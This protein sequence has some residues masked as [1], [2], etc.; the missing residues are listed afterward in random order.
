MLKAEDFL[1]N[2]LSDMASLK[3]ISEIAEG[4]DPKRISDI[5][6]KVDE[7]KSKTVYMAQKRRDM[8]D[9]LRRM[10]D[11]EFVKFEEGPQGLKEVKLNRT[12]AQEIDKARDQFGFNDKASAMNDRV[13]TDALIRRYKQELSPQEKSLFDM[14]YIGTYSKGDRKALETLQKLEDSVGLKQPEMQGAFEQLKRNAVNT[15]LIREGVNSKEIS[16]TNLKKFFTNYEQLIKKSRVKLTEPQKEQL[17]REAEG[18]E[19]ITT[20]KDAEGNDIRNEFIDANLI[21]AKSKKYLDEVKPFTGLFEGKVKDPEMRRLYDSLTEHLE[22]YHNLDVIN[23]NGFFRGIFKKNINEA[24]KVDLQQLDRIFADMRDGTWW[25]NTMDYMT[26][27][28][29]N[30][31]IKKAYY[32]MFPKAIDRD[33][34]RNPAMMEWVDDVGPYKDKLGNTFENA[35]TVRPTSVIGTIQELAH[36]TQELSMQKYEDESSLWRDELR[37]YVSAL[38]D[39]DV[40]FEI[41]VAKR[42]LRYMKDKLRKKYKESSSDLTSKEMVYQ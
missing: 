26:G 39:G 27:K 19:P 28:D 40:L 10:S 37:P 22:H 17:M 35:R 32:W 33:L 13:R 7:I 20:F 8:D 9:A 41:A 36:R 4:M 30:P 1:V 42:E 34:M 11:L 21:D 2:D 16:D 23:L 5:H 29:K 14:L 18:T 24:N 15:S 25:R 6:S 12:L 3:S 31:A 38:K